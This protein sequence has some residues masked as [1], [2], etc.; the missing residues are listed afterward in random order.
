[1]III[2]ILKKNTLRANCGDN[3]LHSTCHYI[4]KG[5]LH[6]ELLV[7]Q[8]ISTYPGGKEWGGGIA[9]TFFQIL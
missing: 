3:W 9:N 6:C 5:L 7:L 1:M 2:H 8:L 4:Y